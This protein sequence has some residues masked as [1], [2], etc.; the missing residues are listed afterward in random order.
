MRRRSSSASKV[1]S[2]PTTLMVT[3]RNK[4]GSGEKLVVSIGLGEKF[5]ETAV[6]RRDST[7]LAT[8]RS[9]V[10]HFAETLQSTGIVVSSVKLGSRRLSLN[11]RTCGGC[12]AIHCR[13]RNHPGSLLTES[14]PV[15]RY[16]KDRRN[17]E[18]AN[19][20]VL[21]ASLKSRI[22]RADR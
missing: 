5:A 15:C 19:W 22:Q 7:S 12:P 16:I 14:G 2:H 18:L 21:F 4:M 10:R 13:I 20:D 6:L 11:W 17:S 1:R 9:A 3:A 8:N